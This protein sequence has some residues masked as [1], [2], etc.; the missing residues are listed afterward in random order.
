MSYVTC[1]MLYVYMCICGSLV[2]G[3]IL[4]VI[5]SAAEILGEKKQLPS[6]HGTY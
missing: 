5:G 4:P 6:N 1:D 2:E 3:S